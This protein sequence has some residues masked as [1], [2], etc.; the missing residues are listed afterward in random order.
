MTSSSQNKK[1]SAVRGVVRFLFVGLTGVVL[2][3]A[4][5][6]GAYQGAQY[7]METAPQAKR[8]TDSGGPDAARLVEVSPLTVGAH[9]VEVEVM[10]TVKAARSLSITPQ[11]SGRIEWINDALVAGGRLRQGD[12]LLRIEKADYELTLLQR[13]A[14]LAQAESA[15]QIE[16]GQQQIARQELESLN[17]TISPEQEALVLRKPQLAQAEAELARARNAIEIARLDLQRTELKA[18]FNAMVLSESVE[19]GANITTN[20]GAASL[21]GTDQFW[22][23]LEIPLDDL[24]WI[25]L[26][27]NGGPGSE[28]RLYNRAAWGPDTYRVG[29]AARLSGSVSSTSRLAQLIVEVDDPIC[30]KPE[31]ADLP[32][33]LLSGYLRAYIQGR[34]LDNV[35]AVPRDYM[36]ENDSLWI[37]T[38]GG[39]LDIRPVQVTWRGRQ[40]VLVS[41]GIA[42]G[43]LLV[44]SDLSIPVNGMGLR[45]N[46]PDARDAVGEDS[47]VAAPIVPVATA[48]VAES[49]PT[50]RDPKGGTP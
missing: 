33:L 41:M 31:N 25:E 4:V 3:I 35:A 49:E 50:V 15:L 37:M 20:T 14:D 30:L 22:V 12:P 44:T 21:V 34:T 5:V 48:T 23:E 40:E 6:V 19:L 17:R 29:R 9:Q 38:P 18:P 26:A 11:V 45:T 27:D 47:A 32:P 10:G 8:R 42:P 2:P 13:E 24:R 1:P 7:L 39:K 36:R 46:E 28:V 16:R 43:E